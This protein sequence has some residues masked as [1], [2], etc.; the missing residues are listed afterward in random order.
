MAEKKLKVYINSQKYERI[1][2]NIK[3][4][5]IKRKTKESVP[6]EF[7]VHMIWDILDTELIPGIEAP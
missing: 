3:F 1:L 7:Q 4:S 5:E 6:N 2:K